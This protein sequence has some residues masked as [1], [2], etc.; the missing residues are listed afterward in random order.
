MSDNS[1]QRKLEHSLGR[2]LSRPEGIKMIN[3]VD[4]SFKTKCKDMIFNGSYRIKNNSNYI[5][6]YKDSFIGE[7]RTKKDAINFID[8]MVRHQKLEYTQD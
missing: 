7:T 1:N 2:R 4:F 8:N 3:K 6:F 5:V